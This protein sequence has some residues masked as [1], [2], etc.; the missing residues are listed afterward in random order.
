MNKILIIFLTFISLLS[1]NCKDEKLSHPIPP[2]VKNGIID[3]RNWNFK[4]DGPV[5]L[6]GDWEFF[7]QKFLYGYDFKINPK[8]K[9]S[10]FIQ[11]PGSWKDNTVNDKK[12][13][14]HGY[15]TYK[16]KLLLNTD[17]KVLSIYIGT[18]SSAYS[19]DFNNKEVLNVGKIAITPKDMIPTFSP[20]HF[21]IPIDQT[22][23]IL[24]LRISNYQTKIGGLW[25]TLTIGNLD[26][27]L[28]TSQNN[29]RPEWF[30]VG[31]LLF[32]AINNIA[33]FTINRKEKST[34]WFGIYCLMIA[35][36]T[37]T[38]TNDFL[39]RQLPNHWWLVNKIEFLAYYLSIPFLTLYVYSLFPFDF[40]K[41][42][43]H[44][45]LGMSAMFSSFVAILPSQIYSYTI[46]AYRYF[47]VITFLYMLFVIFKSLRKREEIRHIFIGGFLV[48]FL[49][50]FNDILHN[51]GFIYTGIFLPEGQILFICSQMY[52]LF[53][54]F[55][56]LHKEL[57][58]KNKKLLQL[59]KLKDEF[60]AN[61]SHELRTPL[62]GIIGLTESLLSGA[63]GK[64]NEILK[65]NLFMIYS[66]SKR[67]ASL[68]NDI[69]DLQK[70]K[71]QEITLKNKNLD[72]KILIDLVLTLSQQL[73][74]KKDV[75][76][77]SDVPKQ[78]PFIWGDENRI[79]QILFNL[80]DNAIKFTSQGIVSITV[81]KPNKEFL[82]VKVTDTGIGIPEDKISD[83]FK[84]FKQVSSSIEREYGGTGLGLTITKNLV[85]LHGGKIWIESKMEKGTEVNFSIPISKQNINKADNLEFIEDKLKVVETMELIEE[86]QIIDPN[87]TFNL[88][89]GVKILVIDDEPINLQV[90]QNQLQLHSYE[91]FTAL[92]GTE[93][94]EK[95]EDFKP[96]LVLLDLMMPNM[97]GFEVTE[98]IR[99]K[100]PANILPIIIL[101]AKNQINDLTQSFGSGAND[102]LNKP[103]SQKE[104]LSRVKIHT[105]LKIINEKVINLKN[106]YSR[107]VPP[108][109]LTLLKKNNILEVNLG[110]Q[111]S[112][113]MAILFTDIR[114]FTA[115][116]EKM[117][118]K[119][120]FEFVNNYFHQI[121][122]II[123]KN[124][125]VI[126][127]YM[128]DA[129]N[130]IFPGGPID[131]V[132]SGVEQIEIL[133]SMNV[134]RKNKNQVEFWSGIGVN[135]GYVMMGIVGEENRLQGDAFSDHVNTASRL[136]GLT[137]YYGSTF[138][139]SQNVYEV[140]RTE[141]LFSFRFLD[142]VIMKGKTK[143]MDI[144]EILD[145]EPEEIRKSK[146][147][148]LEDYNQAV[149][150]FRQVGPSKQKEL[151]QAQEMFQQIIDQNP[152]D[153]AVELYLDQI[154][155]LLIEGIPEGWQP[156]RIMTNK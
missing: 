79:Q 5:N 49:A 37:A 139:I 138:I 125:G 65:S 118:P 60:L 4:K 20:K 128:G 75:K 72:L 120:N 74:G 25:G 97:G 6:S 136:E 111:V 106:S 84:S 53:R 46:D 85:E 30:L 78:L 61:T 140:I 95:L 80:L 110:D 3:L 88:F 12:I 152:E 36:D 71:N 40:S 98:K 28:K 107:F 149:Q 81:E 2:T 143:P 123:R 73:V 29:E 18:I 101:T 55:S 22:E 66:S 8:T 9:N 63:A 96:D 155:V 102:F 67:L 51:G 126:I 76:L 26:D 13:D 104:L 103:F 156:I 134:I 57:E 11:V 31:I 44:T 114:S 132:R 133:K 34:L 86:P 109:Y 14:G 89:S 42:V 33:L 91:V 19:V 154:M 145:A 68:V 54:E 129:I 151:I 82:I 21:S 127:K 45:I 27:L 43:L 115:I 70:L 150:L 116:S 62:N 47:I 50:F 64:I 113:K 38:V 117:T 15:A 69:L 153:K 99:E 141:N 119:E 90:L 105:E 142:S 92:D 10:G 130:A 108:E 112:S 32:I 93:G 94:L 35:L 58:I 146:L 59:D 147:S 131:A 24:L 124:N 1:N 7:W 135:S 39:Y 48:L 77:I 41:I 17:Q 144:Y 23:N 100:Y 16:L 56:R 122:P 83:V 121:G 137:K 52:L 148:S 87:L